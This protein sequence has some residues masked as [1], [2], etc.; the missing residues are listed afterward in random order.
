MG[1]ILLSGHVGFPYMATFDSPVR[2][3]AAPLSPD[4]LSTPFRESSRAVGWAH[5]TAGA[6]IFVAYGLAFAVFGALGFGRGVVWRGGRFPDSPIDAHPFG[7]VIFG[8]IVTAIG[9]GMLVRVRKGPR[10]R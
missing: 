4:R 2:R 1:A 6:L 7:P 3:I 9:I 8:V 10:D 5:A